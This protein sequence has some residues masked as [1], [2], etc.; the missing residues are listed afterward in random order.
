VLLAYSICFAR[1]GWVVL[2]K[3]L[4]LVFSSVCNIPIQAY[5]LRKRLRYQALKK[6]QLQ[7]SENLKKKQYKKNYLKK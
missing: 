2:P 6:M 4:L 1:F 5:L 7:N 3:N